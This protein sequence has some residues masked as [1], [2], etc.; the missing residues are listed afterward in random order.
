LLLLLLHAA[1]DGLHAVVIW[2][3]QRLLLHAA[4]PAGVC[5][6]GCS[7]RQVLGH[8]AALLLPCCLDVQERPC[9][10]LPCDA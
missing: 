8:T 7:S 4:V 5:C 10:L 1:S 3:L 2:G 6:C 9:G